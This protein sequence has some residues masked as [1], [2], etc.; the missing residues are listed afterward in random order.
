MK[1]EDEIKEGDTVDVSRNNELIYDRATVLPIFKST[2]TFELVEA[3]SSELLSRRV[4]ERFR[5]GF[6]LYKKSF[7][8]RRAGFSSDDTYYCQ[9]LMKESGHWENAEGQRVSPMTGQ[10]I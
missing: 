7:T 1:T 8:H 10:V 5:E 3:P 9:A 6:S 2:S 4:T